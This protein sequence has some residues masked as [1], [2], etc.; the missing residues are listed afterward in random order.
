MLLSSAIIHELGAPLQA[1]DTGV[2]QADDLM[3][4]VFA[5]ESPWTVTTP[6]ERS[7]VDLVLP[8]A[9]AFTKPGA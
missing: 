3:L 1:D 2:Y 8:P 4:H 5:N 6:R 7:Q 9:A